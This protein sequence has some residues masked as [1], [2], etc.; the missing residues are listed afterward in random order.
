[1]L[2][3]LGFTRGFE[4]KVALGHDVPTGKVRV[5]LK[6]HNVSYIDPDWIRRKKM[7]VVNSF[8]QL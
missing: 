8:I 7:T 3:D 5:W 4:P 6:K 1:M 2:K